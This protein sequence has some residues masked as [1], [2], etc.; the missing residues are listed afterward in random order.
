MDPTTL[1]IIAAVA[2]FLGWSNKEWFKKIFALLGGSSSS[3]RSADGKT[4]LNDVVAAYEVFK[5]YAEENECP[6]VLEHASKCVQ[7]AVDP[8]HAHKDFHGPEKSNPMRV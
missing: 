3:G 6:E 2:A 4:G 5:R 1:A 8:C 7:C